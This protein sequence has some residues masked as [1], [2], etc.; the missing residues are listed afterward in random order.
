M[1]KLIFVL[2]LLMFVP[3]VF[4]INLTIEK[5]SQNEVMIVDANQP[6]MVS[7][8]VTNNEKTDNFLFY[9]FFGTGLEPTERIQIK[10]DE[11]KEIQLTFY[12]RPD[13]E[14][15]GF[16]SFNYFIQGSDS[17]E[18]SEKI[19]LNV[20]D[21]EDAFEIGTQEIDPESNKIQ[22]YLY[23][24]VNFNFDLIKAK[25]DSAFFDVEGSFS[26]APY[27]KKTFEVQLNKED[28]KKLIAGFYTMKTNLQYK[29]VSTN[30]EDQIK[31]IEK[32]ILETSTEDYGFIVRTKVI[33]KKNNGNVVAD[34][35]TTIEKNI[36]SRLFTSFNPNPSIIERQGGKITYTWNSKIN[37]GE[38]LKIK[39][40]T[41]WIFPFIFIALLAIIVILAKVYSIKDLTLRKRVT[42]MKAKGGE[43]A[44]KVSI[45]INAKKYVEKVSI[46]DRLP[47]LVK[48]YEKF[49]GEKPSK[50]DVQKKRIE[51][52]FERLEQGERRVLT[53]VIYSKVGV[54]GKFALPRTT[55]IFEREGKIKEVNSNKTYFVAEAI[56]KR[57]EQ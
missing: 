51:W 52:N 33:E 57:E 36:L 20:I 5:Q 25:F 53:Y 21:F 1:K 50:I 23:N 31:F 14:L 13:S 12:P 28:Y 15:R 9:T 48:L 6:A 46:A 55:S 18:I 22:I 19:A 3:N 30:L 45:I 40:Q 10:E 34:S 38:T 44:L 47:P 37:P 4:A 16:T 26:L 42:F 35:S 39:I 27:E 43:F 7:L 29:E 56:E 41:N 24:K 49:P 8:K 32:D 2:V 54:L 17:S 11:T